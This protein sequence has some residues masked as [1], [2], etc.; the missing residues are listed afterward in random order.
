MR[1]MEQKVKGQDDAEWV[2]SD[3]EQ[4]INLEHVLPENPGTIWPNIDAGAAAAAYN[5]IGNFVMLKAL[6]NSIIG[7]ASF[8]DKK[9]VFADSAY[10]L[11]KAVAKYSKWGTKEINE[12]QAKLAAI[13]VQTWPATI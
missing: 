10:E 11:T 4:S 12:R 7:N 8:A 5:R 9:T 1:A 3:D 13:A 6:S 2:P